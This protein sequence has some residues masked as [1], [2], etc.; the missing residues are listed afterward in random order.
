MKILNYCYL[1]I[2][3]VLSACQQKKTETKEKTTRIAPT[4]SYGADRDFLKRYVNVI[5]LTNGSSKLA[6]VPKYQGRVMTSTCLSDSGYSFGW[7]NH[8]LITSGKYA[9]HINAYGGEERFWM[10]P[11]GGQY[12]LFFKKGEPFD[13]KHWQTPAIIDTVTF[14]L[15]KKTA[16]EALFTKSFE[17]ANYSGTKFSV[18]V[19]REITLLDTKTA[20]SVLGVQF[21]AVNCVAYES[22][23]SIK[24]TSKQDWNKENG[25]LSIW[26]L[27]MLKASPDGTVVIPYRKGGEHK[28]NDAYFGK[29]PA[30]R[31]RKTDSMLFFK[32]DAKYRSKIGIPPSIINPIVGSYNPSKNILTIMKVEYKGDQDY[33]NSMWEQQK[34]PYS[35]DVINAYNDGKNDA[36]TQLGEFYEIESSSPAVALKSGDSLTHVKIMFHFQGPK[37]EL[38]KISRQLLHVDLKDIKI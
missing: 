21:P 17:I 5:E 15:V 36:E 9:E 2:L 13:L 4:E 35:G 23:N 8:D 22:I 31:L 30:N 12:S 28:V 3:F 26:L 27:S 19:T 38:N 24:N 20:E 37:S 32:T 6:I 25:V 34:S 14:D 33:V 29:V 7:I 11:E 16:N 1:V 18:N 10:G